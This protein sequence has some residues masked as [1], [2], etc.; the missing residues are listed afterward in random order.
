MDEAEVARHIGVELRVMRA[1]LGWSQEQLAK[2]AKMHANRIGMIERGEANPT[3]GVLV[4]VAAALDV[5]P[6]RF[7]DGLRP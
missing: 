1:R 2:E 6:G 4:R 3:L 5:S 7:F